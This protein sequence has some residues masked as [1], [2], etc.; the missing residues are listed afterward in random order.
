M[1]VLQ[2]CQDVSTKRSFMVAKSTRI[3]TQ[4]GIMTASSA[5][6]DENSEALEEFRR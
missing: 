6:E 5:R 2:A 4:I 3:P 1:K